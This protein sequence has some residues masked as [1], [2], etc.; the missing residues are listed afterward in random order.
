MAED[1]IYL[2]FLEV[3]LVLAKHKTISRPKWEMEK[4]EQKQDNK[5]QKTIE[6]YYCGADFLLQGPCVNVSFRLFRM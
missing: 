3:C 1:K 6:F 5:N 4:R 2:S